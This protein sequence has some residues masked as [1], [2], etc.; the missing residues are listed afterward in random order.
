MVNKVNMHIKPLYL[1]S[2]LPWGNKIIPLD[3]R[4]PHLKGF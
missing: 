4:H 3:I 1:Y 2:F